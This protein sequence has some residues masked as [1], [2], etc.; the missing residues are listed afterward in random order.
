MRE[1]Q[2]DV[3]APPAT[4]EVPW[5]GAFRWRVSARDARGRRFKVHKL[6]QPGPLYTT[7]DEAAGVDAAQA[8]Q[9]SG[10]VTWSKASPG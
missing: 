2:R 10:P 1:A 9:P 3:P 4:I 6:V 5:E 7:D 8:A